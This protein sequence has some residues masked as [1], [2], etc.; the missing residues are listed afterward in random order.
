M[1]RFFRSLKTE[2]VPDNG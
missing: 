2:W 1:E